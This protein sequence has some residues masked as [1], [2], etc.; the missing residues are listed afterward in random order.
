ML[1]KSII[2]KILIYRAHSWLTKLCDELSINEAELKNFLKSNNSVCFG[3]FAIACL[4]NTNHFE[5]IDIMIPDQKLKNYQVRQSIK[6]IAM[7]TTDESLFED[8]K[9]LYTPRDICSQCAKNNEDD[10]LFT[11]L[12]IH[13]L[14]PNLKFDI[15]ET[16]S[17]DQHLRNGTFDTGIIHF[18]GINFNLG[19]IDIISFITSPSF[20]IISITKGINFE[21][22]YD[23]WSLYCFHD[24]NGSH[25]NAKYEFEEDREQHFSK[26]ITQLKSVKALWKDELN[27]FSWI[28]QQSLDLP[29]HD[30][31]KLCFSH[32][33][34]DKMTNLTTFYKI[35][36]VTLRILKNV[37]RG[38]RCLNLNEFYSIV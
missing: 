28:T 29:I 36:R 2:K 9:T 24:E 5:D 37:L 38:Q 8:Q 17:I 7:L 15:I 25:L 19:S 13:R 16:K 21:L 35:T 27:C 30:L 20:R 18:D 1:P 33:R 4:L 6:Q 14:S 34:R 11:Y 23:P 3:S 10:Q 32:F 26:I 31:M 22:F 12:R